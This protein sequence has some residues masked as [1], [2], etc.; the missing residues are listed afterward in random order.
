MIVNSGD[1]GM[2][3]GGD[4]ILEE[5]QPLPRLVAGVSLL[6][7]RVHPSC[8]RS[9]CPTHPHR[10][11]PTTMHSWT[12]DLRGKPCSA[13]CPTMAFAAGLLADTHS[14]LVTYRKKG[15]RVPPPAC[16]L[17]SNPEQTQQHTGWMNPQT[18]VATAR[19]Q[20]LCSSL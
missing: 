17:R 1:S 6:A 14:G 5:G 16:L 12:L 11:S 4:L 3:Q 10:G 13:L 7:Q 18:T 15:D 19:G 9:S 20:I 8:L 2:G